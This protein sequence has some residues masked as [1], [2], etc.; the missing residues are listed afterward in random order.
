MNDLAPLIEQ[1]PASLPIELQ[2]I[3][4]RPLP[5]LAAGAKKDGSS[6]PWWKRIF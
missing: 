1:E 5:I 6:K 2:E 3:R 4:R